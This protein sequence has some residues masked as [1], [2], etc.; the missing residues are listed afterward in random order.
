MD[1]D[2][3]RLLFDEGLHRVDAYGGGLEIHLLH[4]NAFDSG[5]VVCFL[6]RGAVQ[7]T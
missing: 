1:G 6:G 5:H 4:V 7:L 2:E 3:D